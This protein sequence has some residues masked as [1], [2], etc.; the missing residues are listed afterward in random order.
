M[1]EP[2]PSLLA[3][4]CD[5]EVQDWQGEMEETKVTRIAVRYTFP[6]VLEVLLHYNGFRMTR[7][8]GDG[9]LEP[10]RG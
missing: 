7:Q 2:G 5:I 4:F 1:N 3:E 6:Q 9:N 10:L 8:Y